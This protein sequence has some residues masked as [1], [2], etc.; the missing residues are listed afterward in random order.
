MTD[1]S[2]VSKNPVV[3]QIVEGNAGHE[4]IEMLLNKQLPFTEEEYLES[5][6]FLLKDE[7][8]KIR[9]LTL[10]NGIADSVKASYMDKSEINHRVAYFIIIDALNRH[11]T[12]ITSKAVRNQSLPHE[13][14][15]KIAEKGNAAMLELLLD[16]Q[17]KL[18][19]YPDILD[20]IEK[21]SEA[22]NFIKGRVKEIR[23]Y[24]LESHEVAEIPKDTV[25]EDV[26][27][28]MTL[29]KEEKAGEAAVE[30][31]ETED[32]LLT[33]EMVEKKA[34]TALQEI[35]A[36][37]ISERIKLALTGTKTQRMILIKDP[38]KMVSLAVLESPKLGVDE[39]SLLAK[40]KSIAGELI[41][42]IARRREWTKN[43]SIVLELVQ[44]PKTPI[45]EALGF[46][47]Q[48]HIRDLQL[49]S[50]DKNVNPVVRQLALNFHKQKSGIKG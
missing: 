45:K 35:N 1:T 20:E 4:V 31:E 46:V 26:K 40:N 48:L 3:R 11:D 12:L 15:L 42:R 13:F 17:I 39:V 32:D 30:E 7:N 24:Y 23:A 50:R 14:L 25:I 38:N 29:E 22:T 47:K 18:I 36:L 8:H 2:I 5:A 43:Y 41:A 34:L 21:N 10:L 37:S 9:A 49:I 44:N 19:A 16:N 27:D 33:L 6:V 28:F